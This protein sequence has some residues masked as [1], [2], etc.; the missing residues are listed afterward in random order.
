MCRHWFLLVVASWMA[1]SA[2]IPP[3]LAEDE[4]PVKRA[5]VDFT[6]IADLTGL[7]VYK[8]EVELKRG[9]KVRAT[10]EEQRELGAKPSNHLNVEATAS[11][12]GTAVLSVAFLRQ[13]RKLASVLLSNEEEMTFRIT[14]SGVASRGLNGIIEPPLHD[15]PLS[16]KSLQ[17]HNPPEFAADGSTV[18]ITLFRTQRVEGGLEQLYPQAT[19]RVKR[20]TE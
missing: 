8:Y 11:R 17:V 18:L 7:D 15:V 13:D 5:A 9:D 14:W 10:L 4:L 19:L 16:Q 12:D 6:D 3:A 1:A 20:I 2:T